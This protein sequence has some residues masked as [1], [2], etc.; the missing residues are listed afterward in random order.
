FSDLLRSLLFVALAGLAVIGY[1]RCVRRGLTPRELFGPLYFAIIVVWPAAAW[2]QRFLLPLLPLFFLYAL[3]GVQFLR[4]NVP[5]VAVP[6][7]ALPALAFVSYLGLYARTDFGP[8]R[9]GVTKAESVEF[10]EYV[11]TSTGRDDVF[12]FA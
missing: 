2:G 12:V 7:A 4:E 3:H 10:F 9:E 11:K 6:A 1:V 8:H 5:A